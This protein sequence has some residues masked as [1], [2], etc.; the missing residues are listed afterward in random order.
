MASSLGLPLVVIVAAALA[1]SQ[2]LGQSPTAPGPAP[3]GP[4][5][6]T[7]ILEKAGQYTT[8]MRL[9]TS[10]QVGIQIA[11]QVNTSTEGMTVFAPT[12]NAFQNLKPGTL[13]GLS[14]QEQV[15]LILYHVL[16]K[17]NNFDNFE[18]ISNPV[19]TQATGQDG[20]AFSLTIVSIGNRQ[21]NVS[22]GMVTTQLNNA[23][24]ENFP[25]AVYQVDKVLLPPALFGAKSPKSSPAT[26]ATKP[27]TGDS[28]S[29]QAQSPATHS[30]DTEAPANGVY[31]FKTMGIGFLAMVGTLTTALL[32]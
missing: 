3:A 11:N 27:K 2:C 20:E 1:C 8:F 26:S 12:D 10:T 14:T 15:Q 6:L 30:A 7:A 4:V 24:R 5:N 28:K 22:S 32:F 25:L 16:S 9:L 31:G 13:N 21:V 19:R 29:D 23:L 18:T 17:F